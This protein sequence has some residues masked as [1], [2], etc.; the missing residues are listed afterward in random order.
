MLGEGVPAHAVSQG[1]EERNFNPDHY[2]VG[3]LRRAV[4]N[5]QDVGI[6]GGDLGGILVLSARGEFF[7]SGDIPALC[8]AP[9]DRLRVSSLSAAKAEAIAQERGIGR[10]LDELMWQA[11][12][13]AS[14]GRLMDGCFRDD[15]V[16]LRH[17]PNLTR[18]P[19]SGS[20]MRISA[21]LTRYPTSISFA[22]R[23][24]KAPRSE[25]Y[26]FYTA[27]RCAGLAVAIN[28]KPVEPVLKPHRNQPLLGLLLN[29]IAGL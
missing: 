16:Q 28:R 29:K 25:M 3:L 23:L 21:L 13:Y 24:L 22:A 12:Y 2:L 4:A 10:N 19:A 1:E 6:D 5:R 9:A 8:T 18:L 11:G 20:A 26:A 14:N 27:A 7:A 15:V 17:W